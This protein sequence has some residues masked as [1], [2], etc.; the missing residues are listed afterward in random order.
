MTILGR[1]SLA[2]DVGRELT[3]TPQRRS[4]RAGFERRVAAGMAQRLAVTPAALDAELSL[5]LAIEAELA[6]DSTCGEAHRDWAAFVELLLT[7]WGRAR[8]R[9]G[10]AASVHQGRALG[11]V[12]Q[13]LRRVLVTPKPTDVPAN[14][15]ARFAL[16]ATATTPSPKRVG[17]RL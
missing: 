6:Q 2:D 14:P 4:L 10:Q 11:T 3:G 15:F 5:V 17:G 13:G 1:S 8:Q 16:Q 9:A 12:D 7:K